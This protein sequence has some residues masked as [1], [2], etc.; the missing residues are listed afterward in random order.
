VPPRRWSPRTRGP[1]IATVYRYIPHAGSDPMDGRHSMTRGGRWNAPGSFPVVYTNCSIDVAI[2]NLWRQFRSEVGQPWEVAE[3]KQADLYEIDLDQPGLIDVVSPG[4]IAGIGLPAA[5]PDAAPRSLTQRI[6]RR[7]H[8]ERR[9]GVWCI[10]AALRSG[11]EIALFTDY[12]APGTV[13]R[14]PKRLREWFP[15][16]DEWKTP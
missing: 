9:P 15:V 8:Q 13:R 1:F 4:G 6:G 12:C 10:S 5:Y 11:R 2:V 16:P 7:L 3:E 14:P